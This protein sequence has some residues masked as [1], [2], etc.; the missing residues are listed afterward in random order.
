MIGALRE[1]RLATNEARPVAVDD[2]ALGLRGDRLEELAVGLEAGE[3]VGRGLGG[4]AGLALA[5]GAAVGRGRGGDDPVGAGLLGDVGRRVRAGLAA[6]GLGV[7]GQVVAARQ[8]D[9]E[10]DLG[11]VERP[12]LGVADPDRELDGRRRR[13]GLGTDGDLDAAGDVADQ[14]ADGLPPRAIEVAL[15]RVRR[16]AGPSARGRR[17]GGPRRAPCR[18]AAPPAPARRSPAASRTSARTTAPGL[19]SPT[20]LSVW[21]GGIA[22]SRFCSS[23]SVFR[24]PDPGLQPAFARQHQAVLVRRPGGRGRAG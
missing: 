3:L 23:S 12:V 4:P 16:G 24:S 20:R 7:E 15:G 1:E 10:R 14:P 2:L 11:V 13:V 19:M 5:D 22:A 8:G 21:K 18:T 17:S 6:V 9:L